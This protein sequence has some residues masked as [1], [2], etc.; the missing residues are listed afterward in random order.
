MY[1]T[2]GRVLRRL[3]GLRMTSDDFEAEAGQVD[4]TTAHA[5]ERVIGLLA[6]D[7]GLRIGQRSRLPQGIGDF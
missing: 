5:L 4:G 2:R 1:W 7:A 6:T 3:R